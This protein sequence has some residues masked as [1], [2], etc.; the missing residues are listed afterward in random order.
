M[1]ITPEGIRQQCLD[2][3]LDVQ[4]YY[5]SE[6]QRRYI[7]H[8][9]NPGAFL[10][11]HKRS[12]QGSGRK[13]YREGD[14]NVQFIG[15]TPEPYA[16]RRCAHCKTEPAVTNGAFCLSCSQALPDAMRAAV[17]G[18]EPRTI[19]ERDRYA[20]SIWEAREYLEKQE[21]EVTA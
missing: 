3:G 12:C 18:V 16:P 21:N 10:Q 15:S 6:G 11:S 14:P 4:T 2:C 19:Q 17:T 1:P 8:T 5:D 20:K 7:R 13:A 9:S